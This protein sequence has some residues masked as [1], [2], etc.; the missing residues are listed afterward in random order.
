M[1]KYAIKTFSTINFNKAFNFFKPPSFESRLFANYEFESL[2][3]IVVGGVE[4]IL[5]SNTHA[6]RQK[7][8]S[9]AH[10]ARQTQS[11]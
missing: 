7:Y 4:F 8:N 5:Q 6:K 11:V 1:F 10:D 3:V 2:K 9:I